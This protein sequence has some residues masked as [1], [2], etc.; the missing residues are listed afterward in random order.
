MKNNNN[1]SNPLQRCTSQFFSPSIYQKNF[2]F[3]LRKIKEGGES[4][5]L[6]ILKLPLKQPL[7]ELR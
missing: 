7:T 6:R 1:S 5:K 2:I 3:V 4:W